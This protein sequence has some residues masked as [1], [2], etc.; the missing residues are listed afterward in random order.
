M[1]STQSTYSPDVVIPPSAPLQA[2]FT[3]IV[4]VHGEGANM[5]Y[6]LKEDNIRI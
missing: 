3:V 2:I 5:Q 6:I 1:D 4:M